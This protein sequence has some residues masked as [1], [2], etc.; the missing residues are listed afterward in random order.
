MGS[1]YALKGHSAGSQR[2]IIWVESTQTRWFSRQ[3]GGGDWAGRAAAQ[4]RPRV[5]KLGL[6]GLSD[7]LSNETAVEAA[8]RG[9]RGPNKRATLTTCLLKKGELEISSEL[10]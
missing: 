9:A 1:Y 10:D 2:R 6:K 4:R 8:R 7:Y 3:S 5:S